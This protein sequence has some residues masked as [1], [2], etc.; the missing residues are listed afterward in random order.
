MITGVRL[1]QYELPFRVP[2]QAGD[3]VHETRSGLLLGLVDDSGLI[4]WGEAA[5]LPGW[6]TDTFAQAE[7]GLRGLAA[8]I[9]ERPREPKRLLP[10]AVAWLARLPSAAA[11]LDCALI[12]LGAQDAG[13]SVAGFLARGRDPAE[14]VAVNALI[15]GASASEVAAAGA[16]ALR[17]GFSAFKLKIG[18]ADMDEDV[19]RVA[20]LREVIGPGPS[21]RLDAGGRWSADEATRILKRLAVYDI[22][23]VEDPVAD[24]DALVQVGMASD[25]PLAADALLARSPDP[26]GVVSAALVEVFVLKPSALGGLS[27]A[28]SIAARAA[29]RG[30][31]VVITSFLES[32]LGLTAAV[33]LAAAL[34]DDG[35]ASGLATSRLFAEDVAKP[36]A[37]VSGEIRVPAGPGLGIAPS[38]LGATDLSEGGSR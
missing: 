27:V 26:L 3:G 7:A 18:V 16:A 14:S 15:A 21:L 20:A 13:E 4:G 19:E 32:A 36:P 31:R 24:L 37:I 30:R 33:H 5:P 8:T 38:E 11:A 35:Y 2:V 28:A 22:E 6:S 1:L 9:E 12:D 29:D 10:T 25:V 34:P 23:Y 17:D